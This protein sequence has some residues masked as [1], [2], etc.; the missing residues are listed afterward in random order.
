MAEGDG[1]LERS[2]VAGYA[3]GVRLRAAL[4]AAG[5]G[6]A[7]LVACGGATST[8]EPVRAPEVADAG[9]DDAAP[10][11]SFAAPSPEQPERSRPPSTATY[12]EAVA[13]PE[14]I[15]LDDGRVQLTDNQLRAPMNAVI[16]AC[17]LPRNA[18]VTV[19][20]AV[21]HGRAIGVT[22]EVRFDRPKSK[23][24][25]TRAARKAEAKLSAKIVACVDK[26]VRSQIWPPSHRR[27][28]FVTEF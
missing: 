27:D 14:A 2:D 15:A 11:A 7:L 5:V 24:P 12:E 16:N 23:K 22:V 21:Q 17:R 26:A 28:S 6:G 13:T 4:A 9:I 1:M 3:R 25:P 10:L 19:K 20:T 8:L 18:K